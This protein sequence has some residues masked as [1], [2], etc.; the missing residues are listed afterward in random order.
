VPPAPPAIVNTEVAPEPIVPKVNNLPVVTTS[1]LESNSATADVLK[2]YS[3]FLASPL[4][5]IGRDDF[6]RSTALTNA[7][8]QRQMV[9]AYD[10]RTQVMKHVDSRPHILMMNPQLYDFKNEPYVVGS[11]GAPAVLKTVFVEQ[12]RCALTNNDGCCDD[13]VDKL[14]DVAGQ[15]SFRTDVFVN[16]NAMSTETKELQVVALPNAVKVLSIIKDAGG[17]TNEQVDEAVN[18]L[19]KDKR[20]V[21]NNFAIHPGATVNATIPDQVFT[22]FGASRPSPPEDVYNR[23]YRD[24][25]NS[26]AEM[27]ESQER[28]VRKLIGDLVSRQDD[29]SYLKFTRAVCDMFARHDIVRFRLDRDGMCL[30]DATVR[31]LAEQ[32][33]R[34]DTVANLGAPDAKTMWEKQFGKSTKAPCPMCK[35]SMT[36]HTCERGHIVPSLGNKLG[37][38]DEQNIMLIC[39]GCNRLMG[40]MDLHLFESRFS[41]LV[42]TS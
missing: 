22:S 42:R 34:V 9:S 25:V 11:I 15:L 19:K 32:V 31:C 5:T 8:I 35:Q 37:N 23:L 12:L 16:N 20:V 21:P 29:L 17:I 14:C 4:M 10:R 33:K 26:G 24:M 2:M 1:S 28:E 7:T 40:S 18:V 6:E 30:S 41:H 38:N 27:L 3:E 13:T 39:A 36:K